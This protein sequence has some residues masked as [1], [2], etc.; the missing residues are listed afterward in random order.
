[1]ETVLNAPTSPDGQ[2]PIAQQGGGAGA[3]VGAVGTVDLGTAAAEV[4]EVRDDNRK[5]SGEVDEEVIPITDKRGLDGEEGVREEED[6]ERPCLRRGVGGGGKEGWV[7]KVGEARERREER[8][9][10]RGGCTGPGRRSE[11]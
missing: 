3:G 8:L 10:L 9:R 1:M 5:P 11:L 6:G 4:V 2:A 7:S